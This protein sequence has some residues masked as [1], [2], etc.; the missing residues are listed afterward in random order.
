M[1][2]KAA[3]RINRH[4]AAAKQRGVELGKHGRHVLA[5]ANKKAADERADR[6]LPV[7]KRHLD[8]GLSLRQ[9]TK[10]LN[11]EGVPTAR[12]GQ[13]HLTSVKRLVDRLAA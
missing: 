3:K 9:I 12:G 10:A 6:L 11:D 5:P 8:A 4:L 13:W 2:S 7:L 1:L